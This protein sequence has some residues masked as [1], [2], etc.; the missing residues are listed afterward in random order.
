MSDRAKPGR[1]PDEDS[2]ASAGKTGGLL[3]LQLARAF[4]PERASRRKA[5]VGEPETARVICV[6]LI[7]L[8]LG[9]TFG[10]WISARLASATSKPAP[11]RLLPDAHAAGQAKSASPSMESP[12]ARPGEATPAAGKDEGPAGSDAAAG[13]D[14]GGV[15][16]VAADEGR[17]GKSG[18]RG[19]HAAPPAGE[20]RPPVPTDS[21]R[22]RR[23][24]AETR[25][26]PARK[27]TDAGPCALYASASALNLRGGA[28]A[29]LV[30]GGPGAQGVSVSTPNWSDIAV[31]PEGAAG[32]KG[33]LRY[34]VR[35]VSRR[36][37]VY[38]VHFK[39]RCGS[40]TVRVTVGRP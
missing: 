33:W 28:A 17:R 39:T 32:A 1:T 38:A 4:P 2:G 16:A 21:G 31:F 19:S 3:R 36:P 24:A 40:Q 8:A 27:Q 10:L 7:G 11:A 20:T 13:A 5:L 23:P 6:T 29:S 34:S 14:G 37:G 15:S 9:V 30:L 18:E 26:A 25:E 22:A 35:S 12:P